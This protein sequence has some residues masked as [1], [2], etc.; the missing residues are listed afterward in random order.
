MEQLSI[1]AFMEAAIAL[2]QITCKKCNAPLELVWIGEDH[3]PDLSYICCTNEACMTEHNLLIAF[4]PS[5]E[6]PR[7]R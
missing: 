7:G 3:D 1:R 6:I 2:S 4:I 5:E